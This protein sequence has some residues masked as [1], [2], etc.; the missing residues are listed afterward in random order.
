MKTLFIII[1]VFSTLNGFSQTTFSWRNDQN[2]P[3]NASWTNTSPY[4]FWNGTAGAVPG[5]SE[6]L[7][8]DGSSGT[9]MTNNLSSTNRFKIIF[10]STATPSARTINGSTS[11]TFYD[12]GGVWPRI[13]NDATGITHTL[14]FPMA[15]STTSG[16]NFELVPMAGPLVFGTSA[17]INN[18]GRTIQIYGNNSSVDGINRFVRLSGVV[19][20]S[21]GLNVSQFGVLKLNATH[22]YSGSTAIDKGELWIESSG[23]ITNSSGIYVGNGGQLTNVAKLWLSNAT[24]GT[25]FSSNLTINSGNAETRF[26][27]GL[28][29]SG[30]NTFSGTITNNSGNL[31][32]SALNAG[33][34]VDFTGV[35]SGSNPLLVEGA[36]VVKLSNSSNSYS[37]GTTLRSGVLSIANN[38]ALGTGGLNIGNTTT[39][40]TLAITASTSR[41]QGISVADASTASIID[42]ASGQ[43][44]TFSGG[45][46]NTGSN[47]TTKFGKSGPGTFILSGSSTYAG[48]IQIGEGTV[49]VQTSS[50]LGANNSTSARGIDLGLNV[51]DVSMGNSVVLQA[52]DNVTV[53]QS[54]YVS[55][56]TSSASRT[57]SLSG[58]GACIFNNEIYT[59]GDLTLSGGSGTIT[60]SGVI[61]SP[62]NNKGLNITGGTV[63]LSGTNTFTGIT[64]INAGNLSVA[65][66]GNGG[67]AGNLGQATNAAA[68]LVLSG[69]TLT[70]T[71][72]TASTDRAFTLTNSTNS[73]FSISTNTLTM[74]GSAASS[75]GSLT[76]SGTGTLILTGLN[77]FSGGV[78]VSSGTLILN[79]SGG[80]TIPIT[81]NVFLNGGLLQISSDQTVANLDLS[82]GGSLTV[83]PG[84]ILTVTGTYTPGVG[85][86]NNLGTIVLNGSA[87]QTF[88]G[89]S[90]N[91]NNGVAGRMTN[92]TISN[93][94]GVSLNNSLSLNGTLNLLSG[95]LSVGSNT[96]SLVGP[97][98]SGTVNNLLTTSSSNLILNCSATGPFTLPSFAAIND[99][100]IG[101]AGQ[102]Y[103]LASNPVINGT[104]T[105]SAGSLN[106][107]SNSLTLN[108]AISKTSGT[109]VG[110]ATSNLTFGGSGAS[111]TLPAVALNNLTLNRSNGISLGGDMSVGG[112]LTLT[113]GTLTVGANTMTLSGSSIVRTSGAIDASNASSTL[114]F[115]NSSALTLPS[116]LFSA[117]VNILSTSGS[118]GVT[119]G[120]DLTINSNVTVGSGSKLTVPAGKDLTVT[121]TL[122]NSAGSAGLVLKGSASGNASLIHSTSSIPATVQCQ[123]DRGLWKLISSPVSGQTVANFYTPANSDVAVGGAYYAFRTYNEAVNQWYGYFTADSVANYG[124]LI[125]GKGYTARRAT[126]ANAAYPSQDYVVY[127]GTLQTGTVNATVKRSA[128]N[129][130]WN[131]IGNPYSAPIAFNSN[132]DATNNFISVN[133]SNLDPSYSAMYAWN[134]GTQYRTITNANSASYV[135]VGSGFMVRV[136]SGVTSLQFTPAMRK[137]IPDI[138]FRNTSNVWSGFDILAATSAGTLNASVKLNTDM[139]DGLDVTYDGGLMRV[140][141]SFALYTRLLEDN[142]V[143]FAVQCLT[144]T[145]A[146]TKVI[147]VGFDY[148]AGGVTTFSTA[149]MTLTDNITATLE[150]RVAG[151]FTDLTPS[152]TYQVTLPTNTTG[153]GRFYIHLVQNIATD[154]NNPKSANL[155][156]YQSGVG[157]NLVGVVG[158]N[159][160]A[161]LYD[162]EGE[163]IGI[164]TLSNSNFNHITLK[165]ILKGV[166]I[167]KIQ[168]NNEKLV[169]KFAF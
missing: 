61:K 28:N 118:G 8:F 120:S 105:L 84:T 15:A 51:G 119:L 134:D 79:H 100:S 10:G 37:G 161:S 48:Q 86:I 34:I 60:L 133:A 87:S 23:S 1:A 3:N 151:V 45:L 131:C 92:L 54:I 71:G 65:S 121:G 14:N 2:P 165:S 25:T 83:D 52:T 85:T 150:D 6:I 68:N 89:P 107:G 144:D 152:A 124:N 111:T 90:A 39:T 143:D 66:I 125:V 38:S 57:I 27:G 4:Y 50:G 142:G 94:S 76:K 29:T 77:S 81:S 157:L 149:D 16:I 80:T 72:S 64:T 162:L 42:V 106:I 127:T 122:T 101:S 126:L 88:P 47:N 36:G 128:T 22:T 115:T 153:I 30:T 7:F 167:V 158:K 116:S 9:T 63:I 20:G 69:G 123:M 53:P 102:I 164:Y 46:T 145:F 97:Y 18:N 113:S 96:L 11:N 5:G 67:I 35:I 155:S 56:N 132:A 138:S 75:T 55:A 70:Y 44:F 17:T 168:S 24:G 21:G 109:L 59:D 130:G 40:G 166:Y 108:G 43:T 139:T 82:G 146:T 154:I 98:L 93:A 147:P 99:L 74:S 104:L 114:A 33:G 110:G 32:L 58:T 141:S 135:P 19:S 49:I 160:I 137:N 103:I 148:S 136:K 13:E 78:Y 112:A 62:V 41:S 95:S 73:T 26:V 117:N 91:V 156:V 163:R 12:Y 31:N 159:A 169:R 140:S 129:R